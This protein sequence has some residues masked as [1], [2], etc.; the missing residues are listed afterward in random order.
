MKLVI[1]IVAAE[2]HPSRR[3]PRREII[4]VIGLSP[5]CRSVQ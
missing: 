3:N 2:Q 5:L 4:V 1:P